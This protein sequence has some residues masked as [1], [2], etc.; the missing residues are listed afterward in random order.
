[1]HYIYTVK[2]NAD[3]TEGRGP[4]VAV[5]SFMTEDVAWAVANTMRGVMGQRPQ[6]GSWRTEKYGEVR[7]EATPVYPSYEEWMATL[8]KKTHPFSS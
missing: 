5:A 1:M 8:N 4:M 2:K 3:M 6:S 7:V